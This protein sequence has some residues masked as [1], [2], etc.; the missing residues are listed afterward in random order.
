MN[1][2]REQ[3]EAFVSES[4]SIFTH[5]EWRNSRESHAAAMLRQL[6][7]ENDALREDAERLDFIEAHPHIALKWHRKCKW[8]IETSV[9]YENDCFATAREA[10]DAARKEQST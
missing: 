1:Y 2:T 3:I 7:A 6:L 4:E 5:P 9:N 8:W 10:I